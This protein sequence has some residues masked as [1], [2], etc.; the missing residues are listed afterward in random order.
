[1]AG[2]RKKGQ[3]KK[4]NAIRFWSLAQ[5]VDGGATIVYKSNYVANISLSRQNVSVGVIGINCW[6]IMSDSGLYIFIRACSAVPAERW[7]WQCRPLFPYSFCFCFVRFVLLKRLQISD[8]K[9]AQLRNILE[10]IKQRNTFGAIYSVDI[11][12]WH[13]YLLIRNQFLMQVVFF[14]FF[15]YVGT[16]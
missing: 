16:S 5:R 7:G 4:K 10:K 8:W 12:N 15:S 2:W 9:F 1:M 14:S 13:A 11:F 6:I 3:K